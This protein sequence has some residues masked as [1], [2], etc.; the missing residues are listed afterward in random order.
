LPAFAPQAESRGCKPADTYNNTEVQD[1]AARKEKEN[2]ISIEVS[3]KSC[4]IIFM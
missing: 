4:G 3:G 2:R 1:I